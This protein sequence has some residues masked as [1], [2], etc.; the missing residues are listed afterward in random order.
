MF[1]TTH[2]LAGSVV[3]WRPVSNGGGVAC[4]WV[5]VAPGATVL[6]APVGSGGST[7]RGVPTEVALAVHPVDTAASRASAATVVLTSA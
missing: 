6:A 4:S 2:G 1:T 7:A 3:E 5:V